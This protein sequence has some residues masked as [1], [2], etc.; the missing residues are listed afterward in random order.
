MDSIGIMSDILNY[1]EDGFKNVDIRQEEDCLKLRTN[2]HN[3][4]EFKHWKKYLA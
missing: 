3:R 2:V 4:E 1:E